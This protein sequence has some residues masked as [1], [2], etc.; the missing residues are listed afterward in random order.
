MQ[1]SWYQQEP[2]VS[3][4]LIQGSEIPLSAPII[5]VGG[6][7]SVLV[8]RLLSCGYGQ[9]TV[10]DIAA[11]A[12]DVART[13]LGC[14]SK[15]VDWIVADINSFKTAQKFALWHDRAL[16]H[17]LTEAEQR[18]RYLAV[19]GESLQPGGH[20]IMG[21]FAV[22]GP[23]RCSNLPIVQ[24]DG[25][26]LL[27]ELGSEFELVEEVSELHHTPAGGGQQFNWF[28]LRKN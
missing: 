20:L 9:L 11:G 16:F 24:Y 10:L 7:A 17:F 12:L 22:G 25:P 2:A 14:E 27:G 28:R 18:Q 4:A 5:D 8:D 6:G 13:R 19:L 26:K 21:A 15:K 1:V 23:D 3:L